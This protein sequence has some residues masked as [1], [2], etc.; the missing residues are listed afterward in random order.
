VILRRVQAAGPP[1]R[2][3]ALLHRR[4]QAQ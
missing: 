3:H 1:Y 4:R 2:Q